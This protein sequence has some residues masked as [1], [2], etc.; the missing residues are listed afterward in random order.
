MERAV[1]RGGARRCSTHV[2]RFS[3]LRCGWLATIHD[4]LMTVGIFVLFGEFGLF[5]SGQF[6]A[7]MLASILM[8]VG[9]S[10]NDTIV[11]FD[12]I[13]EELEL[14]PGAG[15]RHIINV[16][17]SRVFSRSLLTSITTLLAA[18]SLYIFGAVIKTSPSSSSSVFSP[19]LSPFSPPGLYWWHKGIAVTLR[20]ANSPK[21]YDWE[22]TTADKA[23]NLSSHFNLRN[24][25]PATDRHSLFSDNFDCRRWGALSRTRRQIQTVR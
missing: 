6:T 23:G 2:A 11:V 25:G 7:P 13:R 15:L 1:V 17:I 16:A 9:Y 4:V 18:C 20:S 3:R 19:V 10:I 8:I 24:G 22:S 21:R 14:N 5:V 12:R